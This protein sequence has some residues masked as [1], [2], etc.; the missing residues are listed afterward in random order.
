MDIIDYLITNISPLSWI[1]KGG[2]FLLMVMLTF[3]AASQFFSFRWIKALTSLALILVVLLVLAR[4]GADI[5]GLIDEH[6]KSSEET[7][8]QSD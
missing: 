4:F 6:M 1:T 5:D 2:G 7:T 3:R 8:E